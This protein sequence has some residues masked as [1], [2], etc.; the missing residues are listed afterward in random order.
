MAHRLAHERAV[1]HRQGRRDV[2]ALIGNAEPPAEVEP[3]PRSIA[4]ASGIRIR[5]GD[6]PVTNWGDETDL[7]VA[8]NEQALLGRHRLDALA[9]DRPAQDD[10]TLYFLDFIRNNVET[11]YIDATRTP[12]LGAQAFSA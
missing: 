1:F 11:L 6:G 10:T 7:V 8:F 12:E 9:D 4:G 2:R 5:L 3:P